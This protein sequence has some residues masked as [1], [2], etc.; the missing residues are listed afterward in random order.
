MIIHLDWF[1]CQ[2]RVKWESSIH[3]ALEHFATLKPISRAR[4]R[5]EQLT[6]CTPA[7]QVSVLLCIPGPDVSALSNGHTFD[8]ALRKLSTT[9]SRT[10]ALR[11]MKS[12]RRDAAPRGV[13][14]MHRG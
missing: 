6:G 2:P 13:K 8:E 1:G 14:A 5:V 3:Q 7:Y 11:A 9:V 12:R 4:V 10:L